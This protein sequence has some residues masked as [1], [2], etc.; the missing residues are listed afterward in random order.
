MSQE[1]VVVMLIIGSLWKFVDLVRAPHDRL[2]RTLVSCLLLLLVG[3][4]LSFPQMIRAVD[5]LTAVGVDKVAYNAVHMIGVYVLVLF[6]L[7]S[8]LGAS[9]EY[10]RQL[11]V[12]TALLVVVLISLATCMIATPASM[13][14]HTLS[15]PHMAQPAIMSFYV[16]GNLYYIYVYLTAKLWVSRCA[17]MASRHL[18]LGLWTMVVGLFGLMIAAVNRLIWAF[19]RIG[20]PGSREAFRI[21]NSSMTDWAL[22]IVLIGIC[23]SA[24]VQMFLCW[25]SALHHRRMY[26]ELTPL[27]SALV[28]AYPDLVLNR[29]EASMWS[30]VRRPR[31]HERFYRRLIECR[32]GLVRLSPYL[33]RVA[34]HAD[35]A[36]GPP[37]QTAK[38]ITEALAL[39]PATE[40]PEMAL[41]AARVALPHTNDLGADVGALISI[42]HALRGRAS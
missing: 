34:P 42:S 6:F 28:A 10:R 26:S 40:D 12:N 30:R 31:A 27:W 8:V 2:L 35:L 25:K 11:N 38:Y 3:E 1:P 19:Q 17:R 4:I 24:S 9:A 20:E 29:P 32:D 21:M 23:Y 7:S 39:Q 5:G 13:R 22:S 37:E 36:H 14:A 16:I 18:A 15:T 41:F 33:T